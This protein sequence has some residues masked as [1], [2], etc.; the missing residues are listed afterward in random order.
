MTEDELRKEI[1]RIVFD[2]A[3]KAQI[4]YFAVNSPNGV[5]YGQTSEMLGDFLQA[6]IDKLESLI[7]SHTNSVL[8][9]LLGNIED[10]EPYFNSVEPTTADAYIDGRNEVLDQCKSL[11]RR[12]IIN[13]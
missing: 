4:D 10:K 2:A 1:E 7:K 6:D 9:E 13:E 3:I 8:E 11:I 5:R 12:R